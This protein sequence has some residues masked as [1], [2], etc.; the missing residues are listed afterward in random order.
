MEISRNMI[1]EVIV[2]VIKEKLRTGVAESWKNGQ[3]SCTG[4]EYSSPYGREGRAYYDEA[5]GVLRV[6]VPKVRISPDDRLDT[7]HA[8]DVVY[9]HDLFSLSESPRLGCGIMEME[10]TT[11]D[12][13]LNYDEIDYV[14][15]GSLAIIKNGKR[16]TAGPGELILIPKGSVIQFSVPQKARFL[17]V[18]YPADWNQQ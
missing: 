13:T 8:G 3:S 10:Q 12:W 1:E 5:D 9:T 2:Q 7:G 14:M 11:F 4:N 17:Y 15:E 16:V 18:T 6:A